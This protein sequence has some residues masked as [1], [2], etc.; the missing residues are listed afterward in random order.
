M[1]K[2]QLRITRVESF[3]QLGTSRRNAQNAARTELT[4]DPDSWSVLLSLRERTRPPG[5]AE[6]N[7]LAERDE[8]TKENRC[9]R[10]LRR[11]VRIR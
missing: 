10:P 5:K 6:W 2:D 4:G 7:H 9:F 3:A 8:Y 11:P 1:G